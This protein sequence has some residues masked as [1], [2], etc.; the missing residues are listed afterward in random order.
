MSPPAGADLAEKYDLRVPR[1]TSYPT[2]PHFDAAVD[3]A[4][5]R[6]WLAAL[7]PATPLSLYFHI[8]FCD[9]MCW[10]CGCYT[11]VVRQ[12]QPI[13]DYLAVLHDEIRLVG[14]A[15]PGR[16]RARHLH[17][18]GGSPTMLT[19]VDWTALVA[20]LADVFALDADAELAVELDPRETTEAYVAALAEA[21]VNRV[22]IGVQDFDPVVQAAINRHQPFAVVER[23]CA[24][25]RGHGIDRINLDLMYGLPHQTEAGVA[26]MVAL[27]LRLAPSRVALFGYAHVPWMKSH[28]KLIDE[29]ALPGPAERLRQ[30]TTAARALDEAGY[31]PI[32]LDHFARP[33]DGLAAAL[34]GGRLRRNFQGYTA[35]DAPVLIGLGA[36]AIGALPAGYAQNLAPLRAY[37]EAIAAGA[38]P[39]GRGIALTVA[40]RLRRDIIDALMCTLAVD[41]GAVCR[42]HGAAPE[43]FAGATARLAPMVEDGLVAIAGERITITEA[44]RPFVRLAAAAFDAYLDGGAVRHSRAV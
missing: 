28:Q 40:D 19:P 10:F 14:A 33:D 25:L 13:R 24:W 5:Y 32:G 36:S 30:F 4:V 7:D 23:V 39:V 29:A 17:W 37:A 42:R 16:F 44:G 2:A 11:K 41:L 43:L 3:G 22:S 6:G 20:A 34:A 1:Y 12:Y 26:A 31:R 21:G 8:P 27:A 18:G 9:E 38:L 35:D 15:L